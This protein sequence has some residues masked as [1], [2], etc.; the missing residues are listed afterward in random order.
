MKVKSP[1]EGKALLERLACAATVLE[2]V[3]WP[4]TKEVR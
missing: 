4:L 2:V 1:E 3:T